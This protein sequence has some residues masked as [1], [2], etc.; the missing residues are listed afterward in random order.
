MITVSVSGAAGMI[1]NHLLFKVRLH[2]Q[3]YCN[4]RK[5][6]MDSTSDLC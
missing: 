4:P 3:F 2:S 6:N 1:A 5:Q